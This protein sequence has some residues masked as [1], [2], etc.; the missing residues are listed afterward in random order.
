MRQVCLRLLKRTFCITSVNMFN[1][2][3]VCREIFCVSQVSPQ[4]F[5][6]SQ[7]LYDTFLFLVRF[8]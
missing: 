4:K 2:E 7:S 1:D 8:N 3:Q 5:S 6:S